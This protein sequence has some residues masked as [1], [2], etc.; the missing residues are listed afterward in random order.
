MKCSV[1]MLLFCMML[2]MLLLIQVY[3]VSQISVWMLFSFPSYQLVLLMVLIFLFGCSWWFA[4]D[5]LLCPW[6]VLLPVDC[7]N[8]LYSGNWCH[9]DFPN[10]I[11][12]FQKKV[13]CIAF[14][15]YY[16]N[17]LYSLFSFIK[18]TYCAIN[19][20]S[21]VFQSTCCSSIYKGNNTFATTYNWKMKE[22]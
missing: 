4:M 13:Q 20:F 14:F 11:I 19:I 5:F 21:I 17:F 12:F 18:Y 7:T 16:N 1:W 2:L 10:P 22:T 9:F 6:Q 8:F 3:F 15:Q